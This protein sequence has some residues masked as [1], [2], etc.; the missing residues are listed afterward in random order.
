MG[1]ATMTLSCQYL[2]LD[3]DEKVLVQSRSQLT[4]PQYNDWGSIDHPYL[5]QCIATNLGLSLV[6]PIPLEVPVLRRE[7]TM[8]LP[9]DT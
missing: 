8:S 7:S 3:S 4:Q 6:E 5:I 9:K 2:L 1:E